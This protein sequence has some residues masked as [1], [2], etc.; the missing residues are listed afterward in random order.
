MFIAVF[1]D[2]FS[3]PVSTGCPPGDRAGGRHGETENEG[4]SE[5]GEQHVVSG[6]EERQN[7][8]D[9]VLLVAL[10]LYRKLLNYSVYSPENKRVTV[11]QADVNEDHRAGRVVAAV[12]LF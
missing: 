7:M 9:C 3:L 6:H 12:T 11:T 2:V 8:K 4:R 10:L 1:S 5:T